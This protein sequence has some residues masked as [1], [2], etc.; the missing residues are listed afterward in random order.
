MNI[1]KDVSRPSHF[2]PFPSAGSSVPRSFRASVG[3]GWGR[4][5][6]VSRDRLFTVDFFS[7]FLFPFFLSS[8][9][10]SRS[11]IGALLAASSFADELSKRCRMSFPSNE[12]RGR[13]LLRCFVACIA[14]REP[15]RRESFNLRGDYPAESP[16][17]RVVESREFLAVNFAR[18]YEVA[19]TAVISRDILP[20]IITLPS[21]PPPLLFRRFF[22]LGVLF[23]LAVRGL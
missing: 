7:L 21:K 22:L 1:A 6:S 16:S 19:I 10:A 2:L 13:I 23:R 9:A 17:R 8:L 12:F 3:Y 11:L 20:L 14:I 5:Y 4:I 18:F 15:S